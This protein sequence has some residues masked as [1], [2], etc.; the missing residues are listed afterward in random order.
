MQLDIDNGNGP[1]FLLTFSPLSEGILFIMFAFTI[2]NSLNVF[3]SVSSS[4]I[5]VFTIA[6]LKWQSTLGKF[7]IVKEIGE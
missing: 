1:V 3:K 5:Y 6:Q 7:F 2:P 4:T